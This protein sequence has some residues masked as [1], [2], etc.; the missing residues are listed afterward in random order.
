MLRHILPLVALALASAAC[1]AGPANAKS[2]ATQD[3]SSFLAAPTSRGAMA[4]IADSGGKTFGT[5]EFHED[6]FGVRVD[7]RVI[8][9]APGRHGIH[10]HA[11]GKCEGPAFASAAGHF[12]PAGRVH[13]SKSSN[14]PHA[15]DLG[16]L[17]VKADGTGS[18][19]VI[20]PHLSLAPGA[21]QSV[22]L[23]G[24]LAV[25]I[26]ANEDDELTDPAGNSGDRIACGVIKAVPAS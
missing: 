9:M 22:L 18:L 21:P 24:G 17:E 7:V 23:T 11:V 2:S 3:P 20:T 13:G 4:A 16:S 6:R 12:N 14:G 10:V 1:Y 15:G 25:V 19:S 8:G 5:A 26:H